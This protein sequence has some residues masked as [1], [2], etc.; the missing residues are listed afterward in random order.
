[1]RIT[2]GFRD[3]WLNVKIGG[4]GKSAHLDGRAADFYCPDHDLMYV[5]ELLAVGDI[6]YDK[7]IFEGNWL[8]IQVAKPGRMPRRL[9]YTATF[10]ED[11]ATY[12]SGL[13]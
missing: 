5:A 11:G 8:H 3:A 6:N 9:V 12:A 7:V 10:T 2:S 4:A 13:G 1:M